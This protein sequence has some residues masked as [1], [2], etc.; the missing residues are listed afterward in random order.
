MSESSS[1]I[2]SSV[3]VDSP[4]SE[5]RSWIRWAGFAF[6]LL[7]VVG[8]VLV[9]FTWED[10]DKDQEIIDWYASSGNR[11]RQVVGAYLTSLAGLAFVVFGIGIS[12]LIPRASIAQLVRALSQLFAMLV[13]VGTLVITTVSASI[14]FPSFPEVEDAALLRTVES[15]GF[16]M[17]LFSGLI[18]AGLAMVAVSF[19]LR[20]T[21]VVPSWLVLAGYIAG[22]ILVVAG[23]LFIPMVLLVLWVLAVAFTVRT[24]STATAPTSPTAAAATSLG[25]TA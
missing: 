18:T 13:L 25:A 4:D 1:G 19:G 16:G 10:P 17:V 3:T 23:T 9:S 2:G 22:G 6:A 24:G 21:N 14:V 11:I 8:W 12:R 20:G 7:F 15:I 5:A